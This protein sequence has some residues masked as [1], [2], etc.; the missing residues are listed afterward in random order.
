MIMLYDYRLQIIDSYN[1]SYYRL[2]SIYGKEMDIGDRIG[3]MYL[4][5][6]RVEKTIL[7]C[8]KQIIHY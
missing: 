4:N 3:E 6:G 8:M 2:E 7:I 1:Y 5:G